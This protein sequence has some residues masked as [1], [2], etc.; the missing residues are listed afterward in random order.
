MKQNFYF[1]AM[2]GY[3]A[4]GLSVREAHERFLKDYNSYPHPTAKQLV[5]IIN[6]ASRNDNLDPDSRP[7][8]LH[9]KLITDPAEV[10]R[11]KNLTEKVWQIF[12]TGYER[13]SV[14]N[15]N[16]PQ[17]DRDLQRFR[18]NAIPGREEELARVFGL[19]SKATDDEKK[20]L[21]TELMLEVLDF[22]W[23]EAIRPKTDSE[24]VEYYSNPDNYARLQIVLESEKYIDK[25]KE[26]HLDNA[27]ADG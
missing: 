15:K 18:N 13:Q 9:V 7:A 24:F 2:M 3:I 1:R 5:N 21:Y 12:Y 19:S 20:Q 23:D 6:K 22:D 4:S 14:Q 27:I 8:G 25:C 26:Y 17:I 10:E 11:R 16:T